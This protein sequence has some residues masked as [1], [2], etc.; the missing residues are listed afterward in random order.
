[1]RAAIT[2]AGKDLKLRLRDRSALVAG[3]IAPIVLASIIAFAFGGDHDSDFDP[4]YAVSG[5]GSLVDRFADDAF[6]D[7]VEVRRMSAAEARELASQGDISAAFIFPPD[8]ETNV[9][10]LRPTELEVV[11]SP[12]SGLGATVAEAIG[13]GFTS[14][15]QTVRLSV[16][17]AIQNGSTED[18]ELLADAANARADVLSPADRLVGAGGAQGAAYY[19]PAMAMFFLFFST[20]FAARSILA[21]KT[22]GTLKRVR[23]SGA[24]ALSVIVGKGIPTIIMALSSVTII[25]SVMA[26]VFGARW[27][28]PTATALLVASA[29]IAIFGTTALIQTA[30]KTDQQAQ[31]YA[32]IVGILFALIGG[33]FIPSSQ[34]PGFLQTLGPIT[35]NG[36]ALVAFDRL[37]DFGGGVSSIAGDLLYLT[38]IGVVFLTIAAAKM[39]R[40]AQ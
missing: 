1:M 23:A 17:G 39:V 8:F 40:T 7:H 32:S 33:S 35:P 18:P 5:E 13:K 9:F 4:V 11:R 19:G 6:D 30:A 25:L 21:E 14:R 12:Y 24:S 38:A 37:S 34:L 22:E 16:A 10:L 31:S 15:L 36:R 26:F 3:I 27:G 20:A 29:S 28:T 2:I